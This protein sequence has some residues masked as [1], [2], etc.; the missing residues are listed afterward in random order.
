MPFDGQRRMIGYVTLGSNDFETAKTY[1]AY[2]RHLDG[3]KLC[4]F[5][6]GAA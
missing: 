3:D 1:G 2:F 4:V 6:M 5:H